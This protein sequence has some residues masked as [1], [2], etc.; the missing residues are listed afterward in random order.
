MDPQQRLLL[1]TAWEAFE[2]AGIDPRR[3]ARQ[4]HRRV[5]R[6]HARPD[7]AARLPAAPRASRATCCTGT[8]P[9]SSSGRVAYTFGLE[10]PAVTVDT[11]CSSSLVAL[12]LAAQALRSGE[13]DLA[14]AGGVTVM[15]TP[16]VVR[17]VL[18]AARAGRRRPVQGVRRRRRRRRLVRGRR[19]AAARA[20]LRRPPQ[21]APR[22]RRRPRHRRQPG[23]RVQRP[24]RPQRPRPAAGHPAAPWP[25]PGS[26]PATSTPVEAHGTGTTPRRPDRGAGAARHLRPGPAR[27][28]GRC[29]SARSSPTSGTPRPPPASPASSRWSWRMRHGVVPPHP[30]RRRAD[31]ARRLDR[32]GR[33]A[34]SPRPRRGRRA[35]A[36]PRR[37]VRRSASAAPTPTSSSNRPPAAEA[38]PSRR[39]AGRRAARR[40]GAAVGPHAAA[41]AAQAG[42]WADRLDADADA[43]PVDVA[44]SSVAARAALEHRAVVAR[45]RPRRAR[46]PGCAPSPPSDPSGAVV[47][48]TRRR[49]GASSRSCS[50]VRARSAP[51]MGRELSAAFPVFAAGAGRGVR[52]TWTALLPQPLREVLFAA[53]GTAE[54][55]AAGPDRCSRR[56]ACSRSRWP[57]SGWS[58]RSG[59]C[60]TSWAGHSV[61]EITAAHV[62]GVLSLADACALVA[63]RGRLMQAL[64]AGGAMLA[65][66]AA[67]ADV[68]ES[69]AGRDR[70]GRDR[71]RQRARRPSWSPA[72]STALDE[73][74]RALAGPGRAHPPAGGQPRVPQPADGADA[75]RVPAPSWPR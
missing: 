60:R 55:G 8:P 71:R 68:V 32:R 13:C 44:W 7:Y 40:A 23:R 54:A 39:R 34:A 57:C 37:R 45:R 1:E 75:R 74:E 22:P 73:V 3:P 67:E 20:A 21:R 12:H 26:P 46:S 18:P 29:C 10:G 15:A 72:P 49:R 59:W 42:R 48:G 4:P 11:A 5:R 9:A 25:T 69:I 33:R 17:R 63:A 19:P 66:A 56:R 30:A 28:A 58:S 50:P 70:P 38:A 14:L 61:G 52:G 6:R 47:T 64:P 41:L 36:P 53:E 27:R 65:V 16:A 62:A 24:D 51:A 2:R 43:R 35:T 31:P